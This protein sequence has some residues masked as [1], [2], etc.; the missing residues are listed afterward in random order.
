[1]MS[2]SQL[3][4]SL[5]VAAAAAVNAGSSSLRTAAV[6][7]T[8]AAATR[9]AHGQDQYCDQELRDKYCNAWYGGDLHTGEA[10]YGAKKLLD[11]RLNLS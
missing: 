6:A 8:A 3:L 5:L 10:T 9:L 1:M 11:F 7:I 4:L 2:R